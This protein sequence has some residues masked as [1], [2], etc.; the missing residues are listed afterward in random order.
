MCTYKTFPNISI[1]LIYN[2]FFLQQVKN[3]NFGK[4][5]GIR[6]IFEIIKQFYNVS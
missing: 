4:L 2:I 5:V 1:Q 3:E 6:E